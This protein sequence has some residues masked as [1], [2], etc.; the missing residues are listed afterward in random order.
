VNTALNIGFAVLF[1]FVLVWVLI[2]GG[3]GALLSRAREG[4]AMSGFV[5]GTVL[6]PIGWGVVLWRTRASHRLMDSATWLGD[7]ADDSS[8]TVR[9]ARPAD[10][11]A[12]SA[13]GSHDY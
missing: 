11:T 7:S 6:G 5:L 3:I 2:F 10:I 4:S 12:P 1:L 8:D 13:G 9:A